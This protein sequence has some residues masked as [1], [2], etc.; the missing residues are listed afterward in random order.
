M[1][2]DESRRR[3]TPTPSTESRLG[4]R[5]PPGGAFETAG[6]RHMGNPL[7]FSLSGKIEQPPWLP[8]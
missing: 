1:I 8:A 4:K 3:G 2:E 7:D 5:P 6:C